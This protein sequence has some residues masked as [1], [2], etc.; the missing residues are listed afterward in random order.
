MFSI[1]IINY[2]TAEL[3]SACLESIFKYCEGSK[4][5]IILIDNNSEEKEIDILERRYV[6]R[7]KIIRNKRNFGF[8]RANNQGAK[9]AR[10]EYLFF[11]NSDTTIEQNILEPLREK[12]EAEKKIGIIA[13]KLVLKN[14][15]E[16]PYAFG[17]HK[18]SDIISWVS[19]AALVIRREIFLQIGGWEERF[20]M[21]F[22]DVDLCRQ[23]I[24]R[25]YRVERLLVT[26]VTH[27][28]GGSPVHF[29]RRKLFYYYSKI[30]FI[31]KHYL[32]LL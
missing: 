27:L 25:G 4:Y 12:L 19:G 28:V 24:K 5:E 1:I 10:G 13:P 23:V 9:L 17:L 3:T 22:E 14:G 8:A 32:K 7:V 2:N 15:Y 18:N 31:F 16:Q 29:W 21:Y 26:E 11:L 20:F 30:L 6:S